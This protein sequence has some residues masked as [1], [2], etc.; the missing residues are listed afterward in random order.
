M[1]ADLSGAD[2]HAANLMLAD[3]HGAN[4]S[5]ANASL[6]NFIKANLIGANFQGTELYETNFSGQDL[7]ELNFREAK[8]NKAQFCQAQLTKTCFLKAIGDEANFYMADLS[9]AD[10]REAFLRGASFGDVKAPSADFRAA[11]LEQANFSGA[12]LRGADFSGAELSEANFNRANLDGAKLNGCRVYGVTAWN[13]SLNGAEQNGLVIT[14]RKSG[15]PAITVD[16]MEVAQ[17][18][19]LLLNNQKIRSVIDS[20]T[21]KMVLI[22]GRFTPERKA[23]LDAISEELRR[24]NYLPVLF[25]FDV[26]ANR[27]T[28][29]TVNLLARMARFVIADITDPKSIP[30]ELKGI[31][32]GLPSLPIQPI[33]HSSATEYG[34]FDHI[35]RYPWVLK[36]YRYDSH[37][38]IINSIASNIIAPAEAKV[39]ELRRA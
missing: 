1:Q 21:S 17:F 6:V 24:H 36:L 9:G 23:V 35:K 13:V 7:V 22:L 27:D 11:R 31:V 28:D 10:L 12:D 14:R 25:D 38:E 8:I 34:M 20:I 15:D 2:I 39:R 4:F 37:E 33:S 29:E 32:E 30:Q 5:G 3:L 19:N 18:V 26:P 16:N